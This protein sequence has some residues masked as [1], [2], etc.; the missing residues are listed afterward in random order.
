MFLWRGLH[1]GSL[2]RLVRKWGRESAPRA[3]PR[4]AAARPQ[5][6]R[7]VKVAAA[8]PER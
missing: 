5:A 2:A 7:P 3:L 6:A 8:S 4:P 1:K